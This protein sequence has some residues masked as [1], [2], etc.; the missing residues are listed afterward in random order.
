VRIGVIGLGAVGSV[1]AARLLR[2]AQA[3]ERIALAAGSE[4]AAQAL[5]WGGLSVRG[6]GPEADVPGTRLELLAA[7]LPE[8]AAPYDLMLLCTRAEAT[9]AALARALPLLA[10]GGAVVCLQNGLPEER[11][12]A[13][14]GAARTL[15][16]VINWS[17]TAEAP[18]RV[19]VTGRGNFVL[20]G[21]AA[22]AERKLT[23]AA[24][25]LCRVFPVATTDNLAGFRW[26]K[27]A[28]N[29]AIST[30]GAVSGL[31]FGELA[32]RR[33]G[34]AL[35]ARVAGEVVAV[36]R[37]RGVRLERVSGLDPSWLADGGGRAP[38][39]LLLR[40][41]RR[42]LVFLAS[43]ARPGQRSGMLER[44]L[45]GR[46]SGQVDDLNGAVVAA[47][48]ARGLLVPLNEKLLALVH[49]IERGEERVGPHQLER[50]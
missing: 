31:S 7:A 32:M 11:V 8:E 15:G 2:T 34:R 50:L 42:A 47:A 41:L 37:A 23:F 5:R 49:A 16:A 24:T 46:T 17:A 25:V 27:L 30:L 21:A 13:R 38:K 1:V 10:A 39:A 26:S 45:A 35:C 19:Q 48:R 9:D 18:G 6:P 14:A 33:E 36:A 28:L 3:G 20:G 4:R 12:A 44:L 40:P 43:R 29:C 22:G